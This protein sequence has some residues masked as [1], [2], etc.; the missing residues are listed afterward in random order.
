VQNRLT[1]DA[2]PVSTELLSSVLQFLSPLLRLESIRQA[3]KRFPQCTLDWHVQMI[4]PKI[5]DLQKPLH[6]DLQRAKAFEDFCIDCGGVRSL[7][8]R[9]ELVDGV[10]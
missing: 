8:A 10:A 1:I 4:P 9:F 7:P 6:V 5:S 3:R 2:V